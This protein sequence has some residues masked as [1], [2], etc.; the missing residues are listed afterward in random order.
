MPLNY[1]RGDRR[2]APPEAAGGLLREG[3]LS[4]TFYVAEEDEGG[5]E[6]PW[7]VFLRRDVL[8]HGLAACGGSGCEFV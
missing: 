7:G 4:S 5:H 1:A 8:A 3:S 6:R 2:P